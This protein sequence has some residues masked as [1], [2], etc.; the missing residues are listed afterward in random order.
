M[1]VLMVT[2]GTGRQSHSTAAGQLMTMCALYLVDG[3]GRC[4]LLLEVAVLCLLDR[5]AD[6]DDR[7]AGELT[8]GLVTLAHRVA[9]VVAHAEAIARQGELT[10]LRTHWA[11]GHDFL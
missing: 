6:T 5:D 8:G 7:P 9:A 2:F 3:E 11:F 4:S 10:N 1:P